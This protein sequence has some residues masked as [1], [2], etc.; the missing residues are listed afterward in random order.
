MNHQ[1]TSQDSFKV[2]YLTLK[3]KQGADWPTAR[4]HYRKLVHIWHPDKFSEKPAELANAQKEFIALSKSYNRLKSFQS[5]HNRLPFE[6]T[7]P[8]ESRPDATLNTAPV[9]EN[10]KSRVDPNNLDLGTLSR[11]EN[12]VDDRLV[13]K[14]PLKKILWIMVATVVVVATIALFFILDKKANQQTRALGEQVLKEAPASEFNP[15]PAE[16]RRSE[17][18]GAFRHIPTN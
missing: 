11:D 8:E 7:K 2:D 17:S 9:T 14:S 15:T 6:N 12:K 13:K 10:I 16:I 3:L 4:S 18:K 5:L 1:T